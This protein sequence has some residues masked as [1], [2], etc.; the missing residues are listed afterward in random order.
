[1]LDGI[2]FTVRTEWNG[3]VDEEKTGEVM[4]FMNN[5]NS[6]VP[7]GK[8]VP[9][10]I[11]GRNTIV[12]RHY[13]KFSRGVSELQLTTILDAYFQLCFSVFNEVEST[14]AQRRD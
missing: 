10:V 14:M 7:I 8:I 2:L 3:T 1:M 13:T 12:Y 9:N 5:A 4:Q 6:S 11:D